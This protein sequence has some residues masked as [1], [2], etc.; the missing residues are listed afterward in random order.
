MEFLQNIDYLNFNIPFKEGIE[1]E[2]F[3]E[4]VA[5]FK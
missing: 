2:L 5:F 1:I 4:I 3:L